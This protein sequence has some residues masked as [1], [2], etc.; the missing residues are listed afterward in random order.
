MRKVFSIL[1]LAVFS[2]L[3]V[4]PLLAMGTEAG[5]K[6]MACCRRD[7]KHRCAD[8]MTAESGV[9][10]GTRLSAPA[11]RCPYCPAAAVTAYLGLSAITQQQTVFSLLTTHRSGVVQTESRLRIALSRS[12][13]K[14]G[15]PAVRLS[16]L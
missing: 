12:R 6:L 2:F 10:Q 8:T 16:Q 3:M 5:N 1:L 4:S 14:R 15:P 7:G 13:Q 11:E 9:Q